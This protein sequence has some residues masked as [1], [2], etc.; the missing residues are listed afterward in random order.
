MYGSLETLVFQNSRNKNLYEIPMGSLPIRLP[1]RDGVVTRPISDFSSTHTQARLTP[2]LGWE[3][4]PPHLI[5]CSTLHLIWAEHADVIL[6]FDPVWFG[7]PS[8]VVSPV[9]PPL[10]KMYE[11]AFPT[12]RRIDAPARTH[13]AC[14]C[15]IRRAT[16]NLCAFASTIEMPRPKVVRW[17]SDTSLDRIRP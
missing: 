7:Y 12:P 17:R 15:L 13:S 2:N 5:R 6:F 9:S 1:N 14:H 16:G 3:I 4:N 8:A 11:I 10:L